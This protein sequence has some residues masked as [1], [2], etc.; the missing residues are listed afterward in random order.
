MPDPVIPVAVHALGVDRRAQAPVLI[1][2]EI[3]GSRVIPIWIGPAEASAI[4][5][6]L[7]GVPMERPWTHDLLADAVLRLG[8]R[9]QRVVV[10]G[11]AGSTYL[12]SV[13]LDHEGRELRLDARPSDAIALALRTGAQIGVVQTL[14]KPW[15]VGE[16]EAM[17]LEWV[18]HPWVDPQVPR[19]GNDVPTQSLADYLKS[20]S[21][22][23]LGRFHP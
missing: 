13:L 3:D 9:V 10:S 16:A 20:L 18:D 19:P 12:A 8:G 22:E 2:K 21:P 1:L 11:L 23:D 4:A 15:P 5:V 17:D 7:G 14:L 6:H